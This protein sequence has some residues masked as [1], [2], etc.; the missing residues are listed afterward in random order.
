MYCLS[1]A[2]DSQPITKTHADAHGLLPARVFKVSD[3]GEAKSIKRK[4]FFIDVHN[5]GA[6]NITADA[7]AGAHKKDLATQKK[8]GVNLLI[9]G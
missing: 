2:K 6:G 5:L 4:Q 3:G 7:V 8:Y 9:L 1:S